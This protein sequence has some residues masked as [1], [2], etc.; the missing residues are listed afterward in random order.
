MRAGTVLCGAVKTRL[1][2]IAAHAGVSAATVSRVVNGKPGVADATRQ[3]VLDAAELLGYDRRPNASRPTSGLVGVIV[4]ELDNPIFPLFAQHI[5]YALA[6]H[7]A[8]PMLCTSSPVI[9][10]DEYLDLLLE[11][12]VAGI[13]LVAGRHANTEVDHARYAELRADGIPLVF[14]NGYVEGVQA[15]FVSAADAA[16]MRAAVEHLHSQGHRRIGCVMGPARYSTSQRKVRGFIEAMNDNGA[17]GVDPQ[18]LVGHSV[19]TVSGGQSATH[20]LLDRGVTAIVS[21]NDLMA[22]GV[23]RAARERGLRVPDDLSVIG[24]DGAPLFALTDPPLTTLRQDVEA[25]SR[26][27]VDTLIDEIAGGS[28][29]PGEMLFPTELILRRS[30]ARVP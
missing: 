1:E 7:G 15:P 8:A 24:F 28:P 30:T 23:I 11:H 9:Q 27:A 10:E 13:V 6:A 17:E 2:D 18:D 14:I 26:H 25:M 16:A 4:P 3:A 5:E 19:F 22:V 29:T 20:P 12:D 21:G